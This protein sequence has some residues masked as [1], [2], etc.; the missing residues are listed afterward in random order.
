M[1]FLTSR[2]SNKSRLLERNCTFKVV[3]SL[4][5]KGA[6]KVTIALLDQEDLRALAHLMNSYPSVLKEKAL[7][8]VAPK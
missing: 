2:S 7:M 1:V 3:K 8:A 4:G 5:V 6:P